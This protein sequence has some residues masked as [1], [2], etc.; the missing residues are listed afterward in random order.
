VRPNSNP[1]RARHWQSGITLAALLALPLA[2]GGAQVARGNVIELSQDAI[3]GTWVGRAA[4][5]NQDP[6]EVRLTFV[7]PKG[8]VSRYPGDP[9]CGGVLRGDRN[10]DHYEYQERITYGGTEELDNGC[11]SGNISLTV[12]G[13]TMKFDWTTTSNGQDFSSSG[14]LH[15]QGGARKG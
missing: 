10:G 15:R 3:V 1:P 8:G 13:D 2:V 11:L 4:Q 12:K 5:P 9:A 7:S 14:E 6:F